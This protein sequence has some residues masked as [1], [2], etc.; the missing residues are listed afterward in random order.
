MDNITS[1]RLESLGPMLIEPRA[2]QHDVGRCLH[3]LMA[4]STWWFRQFV[5]DCFVSSTGIMSSDGP[6][7]RADMGLTE[8]ADTVAFVKIDL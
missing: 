3:P 1:E 8:L 4:E 2:F 6:D 5:E 7:N